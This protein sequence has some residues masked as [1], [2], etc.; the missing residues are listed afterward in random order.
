MEQS[1]SKREESEK[2]L[3]II[4]CSDEIGAAFHTKRGDRVR[5]EEKVLTFKLVSRY[6]HLPIVQAARELNVELTILKKKCRDLGIPRW[7]HRKMK[8]LQNLINNVEVLKE[9]GKT[10][11]DE[12]LKAMVEMLEQERRLLE[13]KPYV[14]MK[15]KT[16]RLRQACFKANYKKRRLVALEA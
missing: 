10:N 9:A 13:Q 3:P 5:P 11:D 12:Q 7:P 8:S 16:K 4:C 6:F 14:E 15:E 2:G 1:E